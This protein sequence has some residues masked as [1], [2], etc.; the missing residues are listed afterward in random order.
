MAVRDVRT[1]LIA[2]TCTPPADRT[3]RVMSDNHKVNGCLAMRRVSHDTGK[4]TTQAGAHA[5]VTCNTGA[6]P[7]GT[8]EAAAAEARARRRA[9]HEAQFVP[10]VGAVPTRVR[11]PSA[12]RHGR[13]H[14]TKHG[15]SR[16]RL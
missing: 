12:A 16:G 4:T 1:G 7:V 11:R 15:Y 6:T 2:A 5:L 3:K 10:K 13:T 14:G 9:G 8:R